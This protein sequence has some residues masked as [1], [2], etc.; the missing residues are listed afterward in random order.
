MINF[1]R[2]LGIRCE[3]DLVSRSIKSQGTGTAL[4]L[5]FSVIILSLSA[6][7]VFGVL[8]SSDLKVYTDKSSYETEEPVTIV[9]EGPS[10]TEFHLSVRNPEEV[11]VFPIGDPLWKLNKEGFHHF[12]LEGFSKEGIYKAIASTEDMI[13][14]TEFIVCQTAETGKDITEETVTEPEI[15]DDQEPAEDVFSEPENLT[16]GEPQFIDESVQGKV[17][18]DSPVRWEKRVRGKLSGL[19]ELHIPENA[20]DIEITNDDET[21]ETIIT[22]TTPAPEKR[23]EILDKFRKKVVIYSDMHY[24]DIEAFADVGNYP[25]DSVK[26]YHVV[27]GERQPAEITNYIDSDSDGLINRIEWIVPHLSEEE[28][29]IEIKVLNVQSYP[30]VGGNWTVRFNTTGTADLEIKT[31]KNTTWDNDYEDNDLKFLEIRCGDESVEYEWTD[32]SI[33]VQDYSCN[34][35]GY[36]ISKVL[37]AGKHHLEFNFGGQVAY[38]SNDAD[39]FETGLIET[40]G[41]TLVNTRRTYV[42]PIVVAYPREGAEIDM[43]HEVATAIVDNVTSN[44][45]R[46]K[47]FD[48]YGNMV[49]GNVSYIVAENGSHYLSNGMLLQAGKIETVLSSTWEMRFTTKAALLKLSKS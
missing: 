7:F 44:S 47:I 45:F 31:R 29:E 37:T 19:D 20:Q 21:E 32:D 39:M 14:E 49:N 6:I 2:V 13:S 23:E 41:W 25:K 4:F 43:G 18:I 42:Y 10:L 9:V 33:F 38:A 15:S 27:D 40:N 5:V 28:Y 34:E 1:K 22:Y 48:D 46:V 24:A 35:T 16:E 3:G 26:L 12:Y 11:Q 8:A 30:T 17:K 36:E